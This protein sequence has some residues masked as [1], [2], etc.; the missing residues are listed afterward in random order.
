MANKEK[1]ILEDYHTVTPANSA[2]LIYQNDE[3]TIKVDVRMENE[4]VWLSQKQMAELFQVARSS[5]S[6]HVKNIFQE[7]ELLTEATIRSFRIV[8]IEGG[9]NITREVEYYNL[10][11]IISVGYRIRSQKEL[12]NLSIFHR[13]NSRSTFSEI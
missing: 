5:I 2:I 4:T 12:N 7:Q 11:M 8:Q 3:G 13:N 1:M 9:R 6:E 10:D